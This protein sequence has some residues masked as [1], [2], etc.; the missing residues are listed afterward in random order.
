MVPR[1]DPRRGGLALAEPGS[2]RGRQDAASG[3]QAAS[4]GRGVP[5]PFPQ[6]AESLS[7]P[8]LYFFFPPPSSFSP[9]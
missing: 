9:H 1:P 3:R 8:F 7:P 2:A 5:I 6:A 4:W